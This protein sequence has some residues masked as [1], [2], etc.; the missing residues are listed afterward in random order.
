MTLDQLETFIA[1]ATEGGVRA[2]AKKLHKSQPALSTGLRLLEEE[3]GVSLLNRSS[4]RLSLTDEGQALLKVA[5]D[6]MLHMKQFKSLATELARGWEPKLQLAIDYFCPLH[7]ILS[8]LKSFSQKCIKTKIELDFEVL[9]GAEE[10]LFEEKVHLA[11]TPFLTD[12]SR[13]EFVK[14]CD[15]TVAP[16]VSSDL[17]N[18][19]TPD[20]DL[21][22][23]IPQIITKD[24]ALN[25]QHLNFGVY[26]SSNQWMVS[27]HM[28]KKEMILNGFGWGHLETSSITSE[29]NSGRLIE[30][31]QP[32]IKARH[33]PIYM[34]RLNNK[35]PGPAMAELWNLIQKRFNHKRVSNRNIPS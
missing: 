18:N 6:I 21:F 5:D 23:S 2:A 26:P 32:N 1:V 12:Y 34:T 22:L 35:T 9:T 20:M 29:L 27:D 14:I 7:P 33:L 4:Y 10:K 3:L 25:E 15:I 11:I 8:V 19:A 24:S 17:L 28:I 13:M 16:V 31:K 30:I